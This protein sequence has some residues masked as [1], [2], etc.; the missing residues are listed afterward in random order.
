MLADGLPV[1]SREIELER[2]KHVNLVGKALNKSRQSI[3]VGL[4][5]GDQVLDLPNETDTAP[6]DQAK[7]D[8]DKY[9]IDKINRHP[10]EKSIFLQERDKWVQKICDRTKAINTGAMMV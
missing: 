10:H 8:E 9:Q 6:G 1:N 4:D 5:G 2:P 7:Q 3:G